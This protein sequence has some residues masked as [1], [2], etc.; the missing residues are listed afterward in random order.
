M[1]GGVG[2]G[3]TPVTDGRTYVHKGRHP[4]TQQTTN[5]TTE[6]NKT[7]NALRVFYGGHYNREEFKGAERWLEGVQH[8]PQAWGVRWSSLYVCVFVCGGGV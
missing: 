5:Q 3:H 6:T 2:S 4:P 8:Y 1:V 7:R